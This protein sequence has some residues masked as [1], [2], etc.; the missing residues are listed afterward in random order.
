[1]LK[2]K[3]KQYRQA[4]GWTQDDLAKRSGYS[5]SSIIN[6]EK[7]N[8]APRTADIDRLAIVLGIQPR[9]LLVDDIEDTDNN[10]IP[11]DAW[12][13]PQGLGENKTGNF[14]YWGGVLDTATNLAESNNLQQIKLVAP[15]LKLAYETLLKAIKHEKDSTQE[16]SPTVSAYNGDHSSY[17]GNTLTIGNTP[18]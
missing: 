2:E 13:L 8:R 11:A 12:L 9:N 7:G 16:T 6:W 17:T 10:N 3:L 4:K 5:R 1:M 15:L 18:A 14:A